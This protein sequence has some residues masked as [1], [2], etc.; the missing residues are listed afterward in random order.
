MT[1]AVASDSVVSI[2][3]TM[4]NQNGRNRKIAVIGTINRDTVTRAD[5]SRSEGYGGILYNLVVLSALSPSGIAVCPVTNVGKDCS[6]Q[7]LMRLAQFPRLE[8]Q[9]VRIIARPN[10][11]CI[12]RYRDAANKTEVLK[13]WVG[14]VSRRQLQ[15]VVDAKLILINFISGADISRRNL[16]WLRGWYK[17]NI[18]MDFHSRTL[19]RH[20]DGSRFLRRPHDW[21]EYLSCANIAQ[22]NEL[23]FELL[24]GHEADEVSCSDFLKRQLDRTR[25][26]IVTRG[27][28]GCFVMQ[29]SSATIQF[30]SIPAPR[31]AQVTD[32][33]GC[34]DIFS[35][36]FIANY[37]TTGN[38]VVAA[39]CATKLA[40]WRVCLNDFFEVDLAAFSNKGG[41]ATSS[42]ILRNSQRNI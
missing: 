7:I 13:G 35:A 22:M 19:G 36:G 4:A 28:Q 16:H 38:E 31:V 26:L 1:I 8:L 12:L 42:D 10:N 25:C 30:T 23:E 2:I 34:G 39:N 18:Y 11:H 41:S 21:K 32:T 40:S 29:R 14:G 15:T 5:G 9:G 27:S 24:S 37:L 6:L 33:T 20:R 3:D 17:G